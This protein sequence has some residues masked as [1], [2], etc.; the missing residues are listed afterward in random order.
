MTAAEVINARRI[1]LG[2]TEHEI[3]ASV[4]ISSAEYYDLEA[5]DD[6]LFMTL[7]LS[8]AKA[9]LDRLG[10]RF[11]Q[12]GGDRVPRT[13]LLCDT[14]FSFLRERL[15]ARLGETNEDIAELEQKIGWGLQNFLE[16]PKAAWDWNMD[17]FADVV[18]ALAPASQC[19]LT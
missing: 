8:Q 10:L 11:A 3:A 15:M 7:S 13:D 5:Y 6:E 2:L 19:G 9:V 12:V 1:E 14:G 16:D 4:G 18:Q 17:C